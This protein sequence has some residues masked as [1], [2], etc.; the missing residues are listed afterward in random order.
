MIHSK[1]VVRMSKTGP[2]NINMPLSTDVLISVVRSAGSYLRQSR[3]TIGAS[4]AHEYHRESHG[5][6]DE[7]V[8]HQPSV[9]ATQMWKGSYPTKPNGVGL[10]N[11]FTLSPTRGLIGVRYSCD[12]V[13]TRKCSI[14]RSHLLEH[15][16]RDSE[17]RDCT[18]QPVLGVG[19]PNSIVRQCPCVRVAIRGRHGDVEFAKR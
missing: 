13:S 6:D 19:V 3:G 10:A 8:D 16:W 4:P 2:T 1:I 17:L 11:R 14:H 12:T 5:R 7:S 9:T 18:V 15:F